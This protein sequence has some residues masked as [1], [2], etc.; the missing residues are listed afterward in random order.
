MPRRLKDVERTTNDLLAAGFTHVTS[1]PFMHD[2]VRTVLLSTL[3]FP[4]CAACARPARRSQFS[5]S[6][7]QW[8]GHRFGGARRI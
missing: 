2:H 7:V 1:K 8:P 3:L 6:S 5:I 4:L